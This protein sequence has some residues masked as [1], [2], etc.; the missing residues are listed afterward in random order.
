MVKTPEKP[1]GYD[2]LPSISI[3][4]GP[5]VPDEDEDDDG[6][7]DEVSDKKERED[8]LKRILLT[9]DGTAAQFIEYQL[10][11]SYDLA[12]AEIPETPSFETIGELVA[13]H[14]ET[15]FTDEDRNLL[16][17]KWDDLQTRGE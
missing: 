10:L 12:L 7:G 6:D 11:S 2:D 5:V 15:E 8:E 13:E 4:D 3:R 14:T 16:R 17:S 1:E 9:G